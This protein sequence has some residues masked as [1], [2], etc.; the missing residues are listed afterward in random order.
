MFT[1]MFSMAKMSKLEMEKFWKQLEE[2][3]KDP[4]FIKAVKEFIKATTS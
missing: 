4:K 1:G 3:R 2:W